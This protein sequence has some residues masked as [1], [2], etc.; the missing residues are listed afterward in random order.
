MR[1]HME[2]AYLSRTESLPLFSGHREMKLL[3]QGEGIAAA[4]VFLSGKI[5][6]PP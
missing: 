1:V 4:Q 6:T 2:W 3:P 5:E